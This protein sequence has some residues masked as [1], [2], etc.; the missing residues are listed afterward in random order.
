MGRHSFFTTG[1]QLM[2]CNTPRTGQRVDGGEDHS[3]DQDSINDNDGE[4][5]S[6]DHDHNGTKTKGCWNHYE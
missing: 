5:T 3:R 1:E 2:P 6:N 4:D